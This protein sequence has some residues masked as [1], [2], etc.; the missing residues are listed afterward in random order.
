MKKTILITTGLLSLLVV[1]LYSTKTISVSSFAIASEHSEHYDT[2]QLI[3]A[4][5]KGKRSADYFKELHPLYV[6]KCSACH[7][8]SKSDFGKEIL[9][10]EI[11]D[12]I[13]RMAKLK[14]SNI[15]SDDAKKIYEYMVY[16]AATTRKSKLTKAL[17]DLSP[18]ERA[19]EQSKIDAVMKG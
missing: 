13:D 10:T 16:H 8:I 5:D 3:A 15:S 14:D 7:K 18:E 9:P 17:K 2:H 12:V 6:Q 19:K 11:E 1:A 4:N